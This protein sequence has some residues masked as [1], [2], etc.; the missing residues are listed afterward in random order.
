MPNIKHLPTNRALPSRLGEKCLRAGVSKSSSLE[1][2]LYLPE[3]R[4]VYRE[5]LGGISLPA[6][7][8]DTA[9]DKQQR[10]TNQALH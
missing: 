7:G 6:R 9:K 1:L 10:I 4:P 2:W 3:T 8:K 5:G